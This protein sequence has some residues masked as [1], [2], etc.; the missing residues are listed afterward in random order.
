ML[1]KI[2]TTNLD[3]L[4]GIEEYTNKK[5]ETLNGVVRRYGTACSASVELG[6]VSQH[7]SA[8]NVFKA[9]INLKVPGRIL[10]AVAEESDLKTAIA[11]AK[12]EIRRQIIKDKSRKESRIRQISKT[13]N[14]FN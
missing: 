10:Y 13:K 12:D 4:P 2:K 14:N 1:I 5:L 6:R 7:H 3:L 8:G 9:E 11:Q